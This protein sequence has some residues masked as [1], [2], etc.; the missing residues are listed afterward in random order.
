MASAP[1]R[2]GPYT[3]CICLPEA[4]SSRRRLHGA[5][6]F[7]ALLCMLSSTRHQYVCP[8]VLLVAAHLSTL[9]LFLCF[10]TFLLCICIVHPDD[11]KAIW[12]YVSAQDS[13]GPVRSSSH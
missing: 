11:E 13:P 12:H 3:V 2:L 1:W 9:L 7:I 5:T 6:R 8:C 10:L 4:R